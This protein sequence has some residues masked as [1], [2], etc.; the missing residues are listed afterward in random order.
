[1]A[2]REKEKYPVTQSETGLKV[3]LFPDYPDEWLHFKPD[4]DWSWPAYNRVFKHAGT[5]ESLEELVKRLQDWR[6]C[7]LNGALIPFQ[8]EAI[9][10]NLEELPVPYAKIT[11]FGAAMAH[12]FMEAGRLPKA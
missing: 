6:V 8:A 3:S 1:M 9:L 7:D 11:S 12:A 4:C 2:K 10:E 5:T